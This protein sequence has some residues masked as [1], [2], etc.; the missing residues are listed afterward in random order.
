MFDFMTKQEAPVFKAYDTIESLADIIDVQIPAYGD[1]PG[2]RYDTGE[3]YT[4]VSFSDYLTAVKAMIQYFTRNAIE[5]RVV[6]TFCKN[7]LEWDMIGFASMYRNNELFPLDTKTPQIELEH[8]LVMSPPDFMLVSRAQLEKVRKLKRRLNLKTTLFYADLTE[9]FEDQNRPAIP[10]QEGEISVAAIV[11]AYDPGIPVHPSEELRK[12]PDTVLG[13]YPT[14]GTTSLP[15][16]V[17]I[18]HRNIVNEINEAVN[19]LN[20]RPNEDMLNIGPYTHIGTLVEWL[21]TKT[22]G[23]TVTYFTREADEDDVLED[24]IEKLK[25]LKVRIKCLLGVPKLWIYLM[26]EVLEE[27]KNRSVYNDLYQYILSIEKNSKL[28]DI[29]N[30]DKAKLAG[31]RLL[32][33]NKLGGYFSYGISA[34]MKLDGGIVDIFGKL[35]VTVIDIY[36]ATEATGIISR[37]KL[38]ELFPGTCGRMISLLDWR[39]TN[40]ETIPGIDGEVG[41][42]EISGPTVTPGYVGSVPGDHLTDDGFYST[43]DLVWFDENGCVNLVGRKKELT[44]W[45]DGTYIDPQY[46]SNLIVRNIFIKDALVTQLDPNDDFLTV[47]VYPDKTRIKKDKKRNDQLKMGLSE[48]QI[49]RERVEEAIDYAQSISTSPAPFSK[50]K[51]YVLKRKLMRTPTHKIKFLFEL[52]LLH[53]AEPIE[54]ADLRIDI[55]DPP[56]QD[57]I[58]F[59]WSLDVPQSVSNLQGVP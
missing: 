27:M 52:K 22:R 23:F 57:V 28:H 17:T 55:P 40:Q 8:L 2:V 16:I 20:L 49:F 7:R 32:L 47:Y 44:R 56:E 12:N 4:T 48:N 1:R 54:T 15:K 34:S 19:V 38:N 43:G 3:T 31:I 21:M 36:G 14:S 35:G 6:S 33:K 37:N 30:L 42:L 24:E 18:S 59:D 41:L 9:T 50:K 58:E 13:R 5:K 51:I 11:A 25:R 39:L 29:G 46:L 53:E 10:L 45:H 26:K